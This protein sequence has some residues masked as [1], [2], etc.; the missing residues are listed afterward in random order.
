[1][2]ESEKRDDDVMDKEGEKKNGEAGDERTKK[3]PAI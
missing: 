2:R 3:W 1:M